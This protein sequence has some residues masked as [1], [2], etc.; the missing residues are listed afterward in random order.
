VLVPTSTTPKEMLDG[1]K[2]MEGA[3]A[4]IGR[5]HRKNNLQVKFLRFMKNRILDFTFNRKFRG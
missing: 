5:F 1:L 4:T 3:D 2:L